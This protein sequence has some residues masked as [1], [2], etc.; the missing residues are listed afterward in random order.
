MNAVLHVRACRHGHGHS[1]VSLQLPPGLLLPPG[2]PA[3]RTLQQS[4]RPAGPSLEVLGA[5]DGRHWRARLPLPIVCQHPVWPRLLCCE[6][7]LRQAR[8]LRVH[9]VAGVL[10]AAAAAAAASAGQRAGPAAGLRAAIRCEVQRLLAACCC[11]R[12]R[13]CRPAHLQAALP[14]MPPAPQRC[15]WCRRPCCHPCCCCC[16]R[17]ITHLREEPG[18]GGRL[19]RLHQLVVAAL[20]NHQLFACV[21]HVHVLR[22][23]RVRCV[24]WRRSSADATAAANAAGCRRCL[25]L[26]PP[27]LPPQPQA[28]HPPSHHPR[29]PGC[30]SRA[31]APSP[32]P[33]PQHA[34]PPPASPRVRSSSLTAE[35]SAAAAGRRAAADLPL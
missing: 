25:L 34:P 10:H 28:L 3:D 5:H 17:R 26:S 4:S 2:L 9:L 15:C 29:P 11:C 24:F 32:A 21:L 16:G 14:L 23:S 35:G 8:Q 33:P 13:H 18:V 27:H 7:L 30:A 6:G 12:C 19:L 22:C 31:A 20:V 1:A